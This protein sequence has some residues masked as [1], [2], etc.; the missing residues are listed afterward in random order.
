MANSFYERPILN[1]PYAPPSL[2]HPLDDT[3]QPIEGEPIIGRRPRIITL[4]EGIPTSSAFS[5]SS[6]LCLDRADIPNT[7]DFR[8]STRS[9][10]RKLTSCL[11]R[12]TAID[13]VIAGKASFPSANR[14]MVRRLRIGSSRT[15]CPSSTS[16]ARC[17]A[18]PA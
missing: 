7:T 1:S 15:M 3:G 14:N 10:L 12:S 9:S 13:E 6:F 2:Y 5:H 8:T 11:R 16:P 4:S 18:H 17:I